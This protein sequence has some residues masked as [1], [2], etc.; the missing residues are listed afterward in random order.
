MY[1]EHFG[2]TE[3]PFKITP[4]TEFFFSGAN[5]G[6]ILDALI[7]A[8]TD[9]EGIVKISG[10]VGSGKTMLCRM[11]LDRL[12]SNIKAIY[13]ANPSMSRDELLYAIADRLDLSLEGKRV[14]V[15]LQTLQN[16]LEA[17]Y[18]RGERC[19]VLVDEAHAMP[20]DTLEELRLLYNLQVGK[21]KL[22]QI[23][24]F[25]QPE[26]D[27]KLDQSN[28][29]QL[30]DR[31][32]HH[33]SI[34][35]ISRKVIDD[36]LMFRMR[37]AGYK[38]P[39]I[40]SPAS[41]LLI[42]KASQGLMRRVNI[43]ADKA[44]LAAFVENTHKIEVRHVQAAIRDSEMVPMRNWL[45]RKIIS[46]VGGITLFAATLAGAGWFVGQNS[47]HLG[48]TEI[49]RATPTLPITIEGTPPQSVAASSSVAAPASLAASSSVAAPPE[50]EAASAVTDTSNLTLLPLDK[51]LTLPAESAA[52]PRKQ[53]ASHKTRESAK[54][55]PSSPNKGTSLLQQRIDA[56]HGMLAS[57]KHGDVSIQLFYTDDVRPER[58]E[59]F[60]MRAKKLGVLADLYIV[61][62]KL[63]GKDG[64]RVL[65]GLYASNDEARAGM[66][67][68]PE[69]YKEAF[70]PTLFMLDGSQNPP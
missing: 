6:E 67:N 31:I 1:L 10:E 58:M 36:Y 42:G 62:I 20:L 26:L 64:Y 21:H 47:R 22:I 54:A 40:F 51:T 48:E 56:A 63:N 17:M 41:V 45:N 33:F 13:L 2:L 38:G 49:Q 70:A 7:Y 23:V 16:Q 69:R 44:L 60:L 55:E 8:I 28:M 59:R 43:L 11:L 50:S 14:N 19:V 66:E 30:K 34:L 25:G 24:L 65:Y 27:Q 46:M 61:P 53:T 57:P 35:P 12:P 39:D 37:A 3:P 5:R 52:T 29:R 9:G 4:V 15:I 18:E 68:L 32:V